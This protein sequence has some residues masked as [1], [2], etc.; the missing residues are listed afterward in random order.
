MMAAET[1]SSNSKHPTG[2][3]FL[4][5]E[6]STK[7]ASSPLERLAR[8]RHSPTVNSRLSESGDDAASNAKDIPCR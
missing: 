5:L 8:F 2:V 7:A 1:T 6:P 4:Y 3:V